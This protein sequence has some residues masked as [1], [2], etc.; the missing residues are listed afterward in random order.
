MNQ[1]TTFGLDTEFFPENLLTKSK[2]VKKRPSKIVCI[3]GL[4]FF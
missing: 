1:D 2:T 3:D 4:K